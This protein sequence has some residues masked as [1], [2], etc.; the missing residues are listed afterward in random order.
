MVV[1]FGA[2]A[3]GKPQTARICEWLLA[4]LAWALVPLAPPVLTTD[5]PR[6]WRVDDLYLPPPLTVTLPHTWVTPLS[7]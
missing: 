6:V 3:Y 5:P 7:L 1:P 4:S 2:L